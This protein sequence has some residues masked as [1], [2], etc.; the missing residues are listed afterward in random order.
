MVS[1]AAFYLKVFCNWYKSVYKLKY[2]SLYRS[3]LL[4]GAAHLIMSCSLIRWIPG[5]LLIT[6]NI[7]GVINTWIQLNKINRAWQLSRTVEQAALWRTYKLVVYGLDR[8][9][10]ASTKPKIQGR[11]RTPPR[12]WSPLVQTSALEVSKERRAPAVGLSSTAIKGRRRRRR[13]IR[14]SAHIPRWLLRRL[15]VRWLLEQLLQP[16]SKTHAGVL[17]R[18]QRREG[19]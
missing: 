7:P 11:P 12:C 3:I 5:R 17:E 10:I 15:L 2:H 13:I 6:L 14:R 8:L 4:G 19:L 9:L 1:L 18:C 16:S